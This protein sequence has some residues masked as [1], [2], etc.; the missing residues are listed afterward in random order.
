MNRKWHAGFGVIRRS[1]VFAAIDD[2]VVL[3][4]YTR[5]DGAISYS[6]NEKMSIQTNLEN[7]FNTHYYANADSNNNISAGS[8]RRVRIGFDWKF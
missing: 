6:F 1:S 3:P 7:I 4:A 2:Q 5:A 8:P